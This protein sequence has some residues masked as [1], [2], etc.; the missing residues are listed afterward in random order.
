MLRRIRRAQE[1]NDALLETLVAIADASPRCEGAS[2]PHGN[3]CRWLIGLAWRFA[4]L[5]AHTWRKPEAEGAFFARL[6]GAEGGFRCADVTPAEGAA[7]DPPRPH[8]TR[9]LR[10]WRP[11]PGEDEDAAV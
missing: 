11:Q 1:A 3:F 9:L 10:F 8:G 4:V 6:T 2:W 5:M 7:G